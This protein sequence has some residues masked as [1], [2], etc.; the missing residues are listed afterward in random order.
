MFQTFHVWLPSL[1]RFAANRNLDRECSRRFTSGYLLYAAARLI[2]ISIANV[3][4]VSRLATFVHAAA[5]LIGISIANVPDVLRRGAF[6]A[7]ASRWVTNRDLAF[8]TGNRL[9]GAAE[10]RQRR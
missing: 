9:V 8:Q 6:L 4:D 10:R 2:G 5:R 7:A 3:P 1:R